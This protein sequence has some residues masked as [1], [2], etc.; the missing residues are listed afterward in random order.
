MN[1]VDIRRKPA[2]PAIGYRC[3]PW[4]LEPF[5][6]QPRFVTWRL[7]TSET[8]R[9]TKVPYTPCGRRRASSRDVSDWGTLS[10]CEEQFELGHVD[11]I[12]FQLWNLP[13][14]CALDLDNAL[15][16]TGAASTWARKM[17]ERAL[18]NGAYVER[19][20]GGRGLRILGSCETNRIMDRKISVPAMYAPLPNARVEIFAFKPHYITITGV[21]Y[22]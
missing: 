12:G 7:E 9:L 18:A 6:D 11:G 15:D 4:P 10:H 2:Q 1:S 8:G 3:L 22:A 17:V 20:P 21:E 16:G 5:R 13:G 19:T 14:F